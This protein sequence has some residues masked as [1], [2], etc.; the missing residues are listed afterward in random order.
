MKYSDQKLISSYSIAD[1]FASVSKSV[2]VSPNCDRLNP[3]DTMSQISGS[4]SL[5]TRVV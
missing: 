4:I 1:S 2:F 3:D 5:Y